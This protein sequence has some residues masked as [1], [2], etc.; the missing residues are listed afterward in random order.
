MK[1][2]NEIFHSIQG[3]GCH[4]GVPSVFIRFSGCNLKCGF[5]DTLHEEGAFMPDEDIIAAVKKQPSRQV[6]LTGGEPSLFIDSV[7]IRR[8]KEETG[9]PVAIETNGTRELP[10]G[11]DW[12]TVSPKTGMSE[13]GDA[14]VKV[15]YANELKVVDIGQDLEQYFTLP[16]VGQDTVMLL[17]PC[18]VENDRAKEE[19]LKRTISRVLADPR[20]R[21]SVQV[22]RVIG[23]R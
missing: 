9:L 14:E 1:K 6:V 20:W 23:V 4:A 19:N 10:E 17:Q 15:K 8:L 13:S 7:F 16:C 5:C 22:H 3:E 11:I 2:I 12:V 21:L 18:F